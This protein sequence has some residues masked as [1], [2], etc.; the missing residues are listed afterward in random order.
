MPQLQ[1]GT[2]TKRINSTSQLFTSVYTHDCKLKEPCSMQSPVFLLEGLAKGTFYNYAKFEGKYYWIDDIVYTTRNLQEVY[3][4]LDPL[5]TF[6]ND[7]KNGYAWVQYGD[8]THWNKWIDDVRFN[9]EVEDAEL[10]K[11]EDITLFPNATQTGCV[12]L[13]YMDCG[14]AHSVGGVKCVAM[15]VQSLQNLLTSLNNAILPID[16]PGTLAAKFGGLG[17]WRDNI[18]SCVWTP[19]VPNGTFSSGTIN[20]GTI[21]C[22]VESGVQC[23][24]AVHG[25]NIIYLSTAF[26]DLNDYP[27]TKNNKWTSYQLGTPFGTVNI[28]LESI[29]NQSYI[30]VCCSCIYNTGEVTI[31]VFE[32]GNIAQGTVGGQVLGTLSGN[33]SI[34][35]MGMLGNGK[36]GLFAQNMGVVNTTANLAGTVANIV[37]GVATMSVNKSQLKAANATGDAGQYASA[38]SRDAASSSQMYSDIGTGVSAMS[39][40]PSGISPGCSSGQNGGGLSTLWWNDKFFSCTL[41]RKVF[42][43]KDKLNYENFCNRYGYPV[44]AYLNLGTLANGYCKTSGASINIT[45]GSVE[46]I[47]QINSMLNAGIYIED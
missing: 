24:Y 7:I 10:S 38:V 47:S 27:Y 31:T 6:Y 28:P 12:Y 11:S 36:A 22:N 23:G 40:L 15:T 14:D 20:L 44:N 37:S 5:A 3:C 39:S 18:L 16:T 21:T 17:S 33:A 32:E 8:S 4:H 1:I 35:L 42:N 34:N 29:I 19:F 13:T 9:P 45:N 2:T 46:N 43:I 30:Y 25:D 26:T 41:I